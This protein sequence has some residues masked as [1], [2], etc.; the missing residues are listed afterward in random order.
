MEELA[1]AIE[2]A[3]YVNAIASQDEGPRPVIR[4]ETPDPEELQQWQAKYASSDGQNTTAPAFSF[5]W[6][7]QNPI[8]YFLFSSFV[9][10]SKD[11]NDYPLMN[12]CEQV[13]RYRFTKTKQGRLEKLVAIGS[14]FLGFQSQ[15]KTF[16]ETT[17]ESCEQQ[18]Q[19]CYQWNLPQ[20]SEIEETFLC[21]AETS[22]A[23]DQEIMEGCCDYPIN[24]ESCIG[25]KGAIRQEILKVVAEGSTA[26]GWKA[27]EASTDFYRAQS[28][29][30]TV[31]QHQSAL[32]R[33]ESSSK[34]TASATT[35]FPDG[36]TSSLFEKA[37]AVIMEIL[38]RNHWEKF[39]ESPEWLRCRQ[40]LWY[41]DRS[42]VPN[43]FFIMRVLGRGGFGLVNGTYPFAPIKH[44]ID[45]YHDH[46]L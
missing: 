44:R 9:K 31:S 38:R 12:F 23:I 7:C 32:A 16:T 8:G 45:M 17:V 3:Q 40:L 43:D 14:D 36:M 20:R 19:C 11:F 42:V 37:E 21:R 39:L 4:W 27:K 10:D 34:V 5:D 29:Q 13:L 2:D 35:T 24:S 15:P 41:Q 22:V 46:S 33:S 1:D 30:F 25:L 28:Q 6:T 26:L 18:T